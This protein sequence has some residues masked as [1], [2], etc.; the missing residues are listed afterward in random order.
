MKKSSVTFFRKYLLPGVV[1]QS[2]VIA[3]GYGTGRELVEYFL[4]HGPTGGLMALAIS[5]IMWSIICAATFEFARMFRTFDYGSFFD[6]LL[7]QGRYLFDLCYLIFLMIVLAVV[8]SSAGSILKETFGFNYYIGVV[9]IMLFTGL[10]VFMGG[11]TLEALFSVWSF[12]LYAVFILFMVVSISRYGGQISA[13]FSVGEVQGNWILGGFKYAFYN[14]GTIPV[15]LFTLKYIETR[16]EALIAGAI[17]G[18][19]AIIPGLFLTISMIG[20]YPAILKATVPTNFMLTEIGS[21]LLQFTYQIVLFGT[22]VETSAGCI[23]AFND[24]I[25]FVFNKHTMKMP[26]YTRPVIA[27]ILLAAGALI[28]QFGLINLIAQGYGTIS[29]GFLI[30]FV[31]P[32]LTIGTWKIIRAGRAG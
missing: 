20:L 30:V 13:L 25:E 21:R 31:V 18:F 23:H 15:V 22:L 17:A 2:V 5:T 27:V 26:I 19:I 3:G 12:I 29:W 16:R 32:I 8:A 6:R 9:S 14:L 11:K 1:F 10:L 24:R 28:A 4:Q 7:G